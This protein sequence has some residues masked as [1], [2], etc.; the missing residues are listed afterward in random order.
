[1]NRERLELWWFDI[2]WFLRDADRKFSSITT[3]AS[4]IL[5][6]WIAWNLAIVMIA[7][8]RYYPD[9]LDSRRLYREEHR[10]FSKNELTVLETRRDPSTGAWI[11][12][13]K[14]PDGHWY[15]AID[16]GF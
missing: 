13:Q 5:I 3:L 6:A 10:W 1:M 2:K 9:A 8:I 16:P 7:P 14:A 15:A 12:H 4:L 11:W